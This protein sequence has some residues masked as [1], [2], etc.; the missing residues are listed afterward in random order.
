MEEAD[1]LAANDNL[2]PSILRNPYRT[3]DLATT[4]RNALGS[5]SDARLRRLNKEIKGSSKVGWWKPGWKRL[6]RDT[7]LTCL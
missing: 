2:A 1:D 5:M 7:S 4:A 6:L 3:L